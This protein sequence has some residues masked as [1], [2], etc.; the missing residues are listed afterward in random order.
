M[1]NK[2]LWAGMILILAFAASGCLQAPSQ[3]NPPPVEV[4]H[5][6]LVENVE[7]NGTQVV[8]VESASLKACDPPQID[9]YC[10]GKTRY[11]DFKCGEGTWTYQTEECQYECKEGACINTGCPPCDDGDPCTTD[12]CSGGPAYECLHIP[13]ATCEHTIGAKACAPAANP[14][15]NIRLDVYPAGVDE[16]SGIAPVFSEV[17]VP[18]QKLQVDQDDYITFEKF[19]LE[20]GCPQCFYPPVLKWPPSVQLRISKDLSGH[21]ATVLE[22]EGEI[23]YICLDGTCRKSNTAGCTDYVCNSTMKFVVKELNANLTCT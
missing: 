3:G 16:K 17:M 14:G 13:D 21:I 5:V 9:N 12:L 10:E 22:N 1:H 15:G 4:G 19:S 23:G 20:G 11:Y 6:P 8:A 2:L 7:N 18:T